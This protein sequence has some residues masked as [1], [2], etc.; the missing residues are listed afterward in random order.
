MSSDL[1]QAERKAMVE[2]AAREAL[3]IS[4]LSL[5]GAEA[6]RK[7]LEDHAHWVARLIVDAALTTSPYEGERRFKAARE[8]E[9]DCTTCGASAGQPCSRRRPCGRNA[10][11][12]ASPVQ[13]EW[14]VRG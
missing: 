14:K 5:A 11:L 13:P 8:C 10:E 7:G 6:E 2:A 4:R 3:R 12:A 9:L 1:S